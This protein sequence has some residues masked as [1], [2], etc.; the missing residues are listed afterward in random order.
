[1]FNSRKTLWVSQAQVLSRSKIDKD[2]SV[3]LF[4]AVPLL[5][6]FLVGNRRP[7]RYLAVLG[8]RP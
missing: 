8:L 1:M 4:C 5:V 6:N 2:W 7:S 3:R